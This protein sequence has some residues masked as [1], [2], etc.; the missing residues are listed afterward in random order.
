MWLI[1]IRETYICLYLNTKKKTYFKNLKEFSSR[2][3]NAAEKPH[4]NKNGKVMSLFNR[5]AT[6]LWNKRIENL[7]NNGSRK[8]LLLYSFD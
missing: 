6:L 5:K 3:F 7:S 2:Y 8:L 4:T 1:G